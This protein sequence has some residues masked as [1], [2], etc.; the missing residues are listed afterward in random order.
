[1]VMNECHFVKSGLIS[2]SPPIND[3]EK[4]KLSCVAPALT[5]HAS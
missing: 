2:G 1:M 4:M 5:K 3:V